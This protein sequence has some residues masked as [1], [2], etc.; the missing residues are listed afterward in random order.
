M[1]ILVLGATG[2]VGQSVLRKL[3][4]DSSLSVVGT[5][6]GQEARANL[7][8]FRWPQDSL[9]QLFEEISPDVILNLAAKLDNKSIVNDQVARQEMFA[10]NSD[11]LSSLSTI[12]EK[13]KLI[14]MSTDGVFSGKNPPYTEES[15]TDGEGIYAKS[16]IQGE[17]NIKNGKILF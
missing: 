6:T 15:D 4:A 10:L 11:L 7:T 13:A 17:L 8:R 3:D 5:T 14:H 9:N 16:K 2:M 12:S 1:R